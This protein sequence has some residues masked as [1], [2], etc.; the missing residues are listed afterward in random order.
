MSIDPQSRAI[1]R[2]FDRAARIQAVGFDYSKQEKTDILACNLCGSDSWTIISHTDRYGFPAQAA[3]CQVCGLTVL[4]PRMTGA[5]YEEFYKNTYRPLVSAFHGRRIDAETVQ[6]DQAI[7]AIEMAALLH[8]YL[9]DRKNA[10]F[11]DV[12]GST[13][14]VAAHFVREFGV[15]ATVLDPAPAEIAQAE[16]LGI[17]TITS[18]VEDWEPAD[19]QYDMI[20]SVSDN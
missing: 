12:G 20:G 9:K 6:D 5:S 14:V 17:S 16:V 19:A 4:N 10:S 2:K 3:T 13:G 7:Y 18:L 11:L 8:P 15:R 1:K